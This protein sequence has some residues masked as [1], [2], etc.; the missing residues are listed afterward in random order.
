MKEGRRSHPDMARHTTTTTTMGTA[1]ARARRNNAVLVVLSLLTIGCL[2]LT[3]TL[4]LK[5]SLFQEDDARVNA[6][7]AA[8]S[9]RRSTREG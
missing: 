4:G 9:R 5:I 1:A 6:R 2:A 8:P 7:S 3:Y